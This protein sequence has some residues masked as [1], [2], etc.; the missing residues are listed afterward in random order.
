MPAGYGIL[1]S[2]SGDLNRD[3]WPDKI[4]VLCKDGEDT[5][6][7]DDLNRPLLLLLGQP[8]RRYALAARNDRVVLHRNDGGGMGDPYQQTVIKRGFFSLEYYGGSSERWTRVVTF[9][10]APADRTWYLSRES[11]DG[12]SAYNPDSTTFSSTHTP[13]DFGK[14]SFAKYK[15]DSTY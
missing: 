1:D 10:Y 7:D 3:A 8:N 5:I 11:S 12:F 14:V 9:K 4:L 2:A 15:A 6:T 13:R